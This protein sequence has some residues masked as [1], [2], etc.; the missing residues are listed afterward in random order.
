LASRLSRAEVPGDRA[1]R[2]MPN[3]VKHLDPGATDTELRSRLA[4]RS[5][6]PPPEMGR[7]L[8]AI[9][10]MHEAPSRPFLGAYLLEARQD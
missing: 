4:T 1:I 8:R 7:T 6:I 5:P 9:Q 10:R 3:I 2:A